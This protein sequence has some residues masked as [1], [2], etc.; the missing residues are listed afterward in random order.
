MRNEI[1][2]DALNHLDDDMI[3]EVD[4]LRNSKKQ[5]R[6][7]PWSRVT[8]IAASVCLLF[9]GGYAWE[10]YLKPIED[11]MLGE[12][13]GHRP[14][15]SSSRDENLNE[16]I[17]ETEGTQDKNDPVDSVMES[18]AKPD[19]SETVDPGE[20]D[21]YAPLGDAYLLKDNY[22][23]ITILPHKVWSEEAALE[24]EL[25]KSVE[26]E[27]R[28]YEAFDRFI[29]ALC[30]TPRMRS[31]YVLS[32]TNPDTDMIYHIFFH[33]A[34]GTIVHVWMYDDRYVCYD[35]D[36]DFCMQIDRTVYANVFKLL[37]IYW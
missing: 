36:R 5:I 23:K 25:S 29:E 14:G 37:A 15:T 35:A 19:V 6:K 18:E 8:A 33:K 26:I 11:E 34:D 27:S 9:I 20:P 3:E 30:D 4:K 13:N 2:H 31:E 22:T 7:F 28:D 12:T 16:G 17:C 1:I 10:N 24:D 32:V 21:H